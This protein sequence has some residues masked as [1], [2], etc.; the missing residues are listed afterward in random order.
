MGVISKFWQG[1]WGEWI[2]AEYLAYLIPSHGTSSS[3]G[4]QF[5]L[6]PS[7]LYSGHSRCSSRRAMEMFFWGFRLGLSFTSQGVNLTES[8]RSVECLWLSTFDHLWI[9]QALDMMNFS[10]HFV[11]PVISLYHLL[12]RYMKKHPQLFFQHGRRLCGPW[13]LGRSSLGS[14]PPCSTSTTA[15]QPCRQGGRCGHGRCGHGGKAF[16]AAVAAV[17]GEGHGGGDATGVV[18]GSS[19]RICEEF[20]TWTT[21]RIEE[22]VSRGGC[23]DGGIEI[24]SWGLRRGLGSRWTCFLMSK[25]LFWNFDFDL[26]SN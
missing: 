4:S 11:R 9:L 10:K 6:R 17:R 21:R 25:S 23:G 12:C 22:I 13:R 1:G 8:C 15:G 26:F 20:D 5:S 2:Q 18:G 14:M 16:P 24:S 7:S 3:W 19:W